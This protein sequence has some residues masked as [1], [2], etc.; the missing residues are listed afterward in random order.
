MRPLSGDV[1]GPKKVNEGGGEGYD[2]RSKK[3]WTEGKGRAC[4]HC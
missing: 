3:E 4:H 2:T 1:D